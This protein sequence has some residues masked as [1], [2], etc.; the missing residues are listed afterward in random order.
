LTGRRPDGKLCEVKCDLCRLACR[1][2]KGFND[3]EI[4]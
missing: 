3:E 2:V 4:T 1:I